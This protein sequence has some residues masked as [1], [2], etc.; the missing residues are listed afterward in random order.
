ML[1]KMVFLAV[2]FCTS[3]I[4]NQKRGQKKEASEE[5]DGLEKGYDGCKSENWQK[6]GKLEDIQNYGKSILI[7][8]P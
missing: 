4:V 7:S 8:L 5:R 1:L 3:T 2:A 6:R